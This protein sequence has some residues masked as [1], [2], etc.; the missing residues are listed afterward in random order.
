MRLRVW[1]E[2][3]RVL[4]LE[5]SLL[6]RMVTA[7][8]RINLRDRALSLAGQ[9][10]MALVPMAIVLATVLTSTDAQAVGDWIISEFELS[11][12]AAQ[13]VATLFSRP[14]DATSGI[15][16]VGLLLLLMSLASFARL[17]QRTFELAWELP[18]GYRRRT[19][20]GLRGASALLLTLG[21]MAAL[22]GALS[23][24]IDRPLAVRLLTLLVAVPAWWGMTYLFLGGRVSWTMLLPGAVVA[25]V[26]HVLTSVGSALWMPFLIERNAERYGVIGVAV[27]LITWL[28][29]L[30][31]LIVTSAVVQAQLG[32]ALTRRG[33]GSSD[34]D[35]GSIEETDHS[36]RVR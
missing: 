11:G 30:A 31:F 1:R 36:G 22:S 34:T 16:V 4:A 27:A 29:V 19:V 35:R 25:A 10:F 28:L 6:G 7:L 2:H 23:D 9:A 24:V 8:F 33:G 17:V 18:P 13:A 32:P 15:G 20:D 14:P 26:G 3:P 21:G 5:D 12:T